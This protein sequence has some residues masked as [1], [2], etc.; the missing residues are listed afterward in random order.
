[1][2]GHDLGRS[3]SLKKWKIAVPDAA[4]PPKPGSGA[5]TGESV[6]RSAGMIWHIA[7]PPDIPSPFDRSEQLAPDLGAH[8]QTGLLFALPFQVL[9]AHERRAVVIA[10]TDQPRVL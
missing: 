8:P 5:P 10:I 4:A 7:G 1:M 6:I 2:K 3:Q 9:T